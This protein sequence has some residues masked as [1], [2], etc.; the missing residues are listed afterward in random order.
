[1][2]RGMVA[3]ARGHIISVTNLGSRHLGTHNLLGGILARSEIPCALASRE[4]VVRFQSRAKRNGILICKL[5]QTTNSSKLQYW[6]AFSK[7]FLVV[8]LSV[9]G[10]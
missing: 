2:E 4:P 5:D 9:R 10:R 7:R 8:E 6:W 1:M 3:I